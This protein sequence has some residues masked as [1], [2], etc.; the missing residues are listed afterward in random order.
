MF[1]TQA[2]LLATYTFPK[3]LS[4]PS[5]DSG[6]DAPH[7]FESISFGGDA[8]DADGADF[9]TTRHMCNATALARD[10]A[11]ER[12]DVATPEYMAAVANSV[13]AHGATRWCCCGPLR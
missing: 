12:A 8:A 3:Y 1:A 6:E 5:A 7:R 4:A 10:L 11:T 13:S 2:S 9:T